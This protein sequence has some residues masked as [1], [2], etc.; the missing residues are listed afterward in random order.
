MNPIRSVSMSPLAAKRIKKGKV[1][2]PA[3]NISKVSIHSQNFF[4]FFNMSENQNP[5][6][7]G[8]YYETS[9]AKTILQFS[10]HLQ[11][12]CSHK[13]MSRL[14]EFEIPRIWVQVL[15]PITQYRRRSLCPHTH[16]SSIYTQSLTLQ[17]PL[18]ILQT[19]NASFAT[20]SKL[21]FFIGLFL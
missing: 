2:F 13:P 18:T 5:S 15:M 10:T 8:Q 6:L 4:F 20:T 9:L 11:L 19:V 17:T 1:F 14:G 16:P 7:S 3:V 12:V 21:F